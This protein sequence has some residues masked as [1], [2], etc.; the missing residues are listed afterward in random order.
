MSTVT[1]PTN[2]ITLRLLGAMVMFVHEIIRLMNFHITLK[3]IT[4]V[5]INNFC[6]IIK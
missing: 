6:D 4:I 2:N 5:K 3:Q 1:I